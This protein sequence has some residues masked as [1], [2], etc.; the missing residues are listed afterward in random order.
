[1]ILQVL[2]AKP[3]KIMYSKPNIPTDRWSLAR[4]YAWI[5]RCDHDVFWCLRSI[6]SVDTL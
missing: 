5:S 6:G 2:I 3:V 1:L 4:G